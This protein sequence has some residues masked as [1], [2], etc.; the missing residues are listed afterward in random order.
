ML[1]SSETKAL[2]GKALGRGALLAR[3]G[4]GVQVKAV[5]GS[6]AAAGCGEADG[7]YGWL[8]GG[9]NQILWHSIYGERMTYTLA[10]TNAAKTA[11]DIGTKGGDSGSPVYWWDEAKQKWWLIAANQA[12]G[13]GEGYAKDSYLRSAPDGRK[14]ALQVTLMHRLTPQAQLHLLLG[15]SKIRQRARVN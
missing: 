13:G 7:C 5:D 3:A 8:S 9:L 4:G 6:T 14:N 12:G 2:L 15:K 10:I 11:L 1:S